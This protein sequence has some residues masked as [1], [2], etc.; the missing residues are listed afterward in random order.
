MLLFLGRLVPTK[1]VDR[2]IRAAA[3][4][5]GPVEIRVAG[6]GP[7]RAN[8]ERLARSLGVDARFEGWVH[9]ERK[10]KLLGSC[11]ALV[12]P[13]RADDGVPTVVFEAIAR[14]LPVVATDLDG[15]EAHLPRASRI[16]P[17]DIPALTTAL[18]S[19]HAAS[20]R[21]RSTTV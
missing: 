10:E 6:D 15:L 18:R 4:L 21:P 1:G 16:P 2:L 17:E 11:D 13:S 12:V 19:L 5:P 20:T 9:G 14:G 7:E 8:L 3:A